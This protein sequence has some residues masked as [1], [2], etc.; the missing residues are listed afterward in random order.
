VRENNLLNQARDV[1]YVRLV[2]DLRDVAAEPGR[3]L[4]ILNQRLREIPRGGSP[5]DDFATAFYAVIEMV[6]GKLQFAAAGHPSPLRIRRRTG[7]TV[8]RL[9]ETH[10]VS[11]PALGLFPYVVYPV[12]E[13]SLEPDDALVMFTDGISEAEDH[14]GNMLGEA[15]LASLVSERACHDMELLLPNLIERVR[16]VVGH[17]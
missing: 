4:T 5:L 14:G 16:E 15:R 9:I 11:G 6:V 2:L 3:F 13:I 17:A 1:R 8:S 7:G 12:S 10:D